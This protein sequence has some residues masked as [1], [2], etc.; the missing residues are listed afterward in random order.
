MYPLA[1]WSRWAVDLPLKADY[2]RSPSG[3]GPFSYCTGGVLLLGQVVQARDLASRSTSTS[4]SGCCA[5]SASASGKWARSP[6]GEFQTGG[7]LELRSRDLLKLGVLIGA[8]RQL[9]RHAAG[10]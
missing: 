6:S 2:Q 1:N 5:R 8:Q 9:A 4:M 10:S 3:R 7:G